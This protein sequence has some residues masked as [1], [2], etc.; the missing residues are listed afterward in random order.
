MFGTHF[1]DY[2]VQ[3]KKDHDHG[4]KRT[5]QLA[6]VIPSEDLRVIR[7]LGEGQYGV[8]ELGEWKSPNGDKVSG[9][10]SND[11]LYFFSIVECSRNLIVNLYTI[12]LLKILLN[13]KQY[14]TVIY[15]P[16]LK[17]HV[18]IMIVHTGLPLIDIP[19]LAVCRMFVA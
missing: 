14:T 4:Q 2:N 12:I 11:L 10:S 3:E 13:K 19:I 9:S 18:S 1:Y 16:G 7:E 17:D 5:S 8:V 6:Y 15:S